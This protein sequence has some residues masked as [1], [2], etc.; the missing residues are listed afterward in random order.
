MSWLRRQDELTEDD[1]GRA[2]RYLEDAGEFSTVRSERCNSPHDRARWEKDRNVRTVR[3]GGPPTVA[4]LEQ[5]D[6]VVAHFG[7]ERCAVGGRRSCA[8]GP[9]EMSEFFGSALGADPEPS[10]ATTQPSNDETDKDQRGGRCNRFRIVDGNPPVRLGVN[11]AEDQTRAQCRHERRPECSEQG[12]RDDRHDEDDR[13]QLWML[14]AKRQQRQPGETG[15]NDGQHI[16]HGQTP[17][18]R[19]QP[20]AGCKQLRSLTTTG[21]ALSRGRRTPPMRP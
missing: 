20:L 7:S 16:R 21:C 6:Q 18:R 13:D 3:V 11:H 17:T 19:A 8:G 5:R 14:S 10:D 1:V 9:E 2:R 12:R 4:Q 15:Q